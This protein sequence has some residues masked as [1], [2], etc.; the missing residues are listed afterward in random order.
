MGEAISRAI[1]GVVAHDSLHVCW[2]NPNT[3]MPSFGFWHR[4]TAEVG[5]AQTI[6]YYSGQ[7]LTHPVEQARRG[8]PVQVV[9]AH[10]RL[11]HK[12]L[13]DN[14][15]AGELRLLLR[16]AHGTWGTLVL[17]REQ[18]AAPF[19]QGDVDRVA[20]LAQPLVAVSRSYVRATPLHSP[21]GDLPPGVIVVGADHA[22]RGITP[23]GH[24]WLRAIRLPGALT[25][26]EWA[27]VALSS[28]VALAGR[29]FVRDPTTPRP[30]T[31][32]PSAYAGRWVGVQG[33]PLDADGTGDVAVVIRA[34][35][36]ELLPALSAWYDVTGR[37]R[38]V[39]DE[40]R[41]GIPAKQIARRLALSVHTVN[42]YLKAIYRKTGI[43]G[44]DEITAVLS[45]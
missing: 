29:R 23:E 27:A 14:G 43:A 36:A 7:D 44:R 17:L 12:V 30:V 10:D 5:R 6:N 32:L 19:G 40:L 9:D 4:L 3:D 15:Y 26:P 28:E 1:S 33:Q 34:A 24:A 35:G 31:C 45:G 22:V 38:A 16:A 25:E 39:I 8:I 20:R 2:R 37:E 13:L 21:D 11:A 42:D 18:G 41:E